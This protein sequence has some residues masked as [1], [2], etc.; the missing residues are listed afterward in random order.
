MRA[1]TAAPGTADCVLQWGSLLGLGI[2]FLDAFF[3]PWLPTQQI[4]Q[5]GGSSI[6]VSW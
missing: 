5:M 6:M 4:R 3:F 1:A 2:C